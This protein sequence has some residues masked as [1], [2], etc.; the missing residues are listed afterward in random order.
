M[1]AIALQISVRSSGQTLLAAQKRN[2][3]ISYISDPI[4]AFWAMRNRTNRS[5]SIM[6]DIFLSD[7]QIAAVYSVHRMT[8]WRWLKSDPTFPKPFRLSGRCT[9]WKK[10]EIEAWEAS[11]ASD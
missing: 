1:L 4:A 6:N 11:K 7:V 9:R 10:S 5:E 8:V 3:E 2:F